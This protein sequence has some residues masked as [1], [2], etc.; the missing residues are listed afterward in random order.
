MKLHEALSSPKRLRRKG[1]TEWRE[2]GLTMDSPVYSY[3]DVK[4]DDWELEE[5][6]V[7]IT[8]DQWVNILAA[9]VR[10]ASEDATIWRGSNNILMEQTYYNRVLQNI[11]KRMFKEDT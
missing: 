4:A 11:K 2:L 8:E 5:L 3:S 7:T 1:E 6:S 10:E 9:S